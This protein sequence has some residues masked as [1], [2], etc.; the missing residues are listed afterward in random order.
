MNVRK[1]RQI[2]KKFLG[3]YFWKDV[4]PESALKQF[5]VVDD[6]FD[7]EDDVIKY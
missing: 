4:S 5:H 1:L 3:I 7:E 6:K 2:P